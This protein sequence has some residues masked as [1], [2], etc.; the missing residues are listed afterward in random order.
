MKLPR[1]GTDWRRRWCYTARGNQLHRVA[2]ISY[3]DADRIV[4]H[5]ATAC[6]LFAEL[7]MPG[8]IGRMGSPRCRKCC[9]VA[10]IAHGTGAP[11]NEGIDA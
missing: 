3:V 5:G 9:D 8:F 11:T 6:G 7:H 2:S 10:G 4:G 1:F